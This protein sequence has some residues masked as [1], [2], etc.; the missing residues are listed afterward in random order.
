[1]I[2]TTVSFLNIAEDVSIKVFKKPIRSLKHDQ[3]TNSSCRNLL[4]HET[5]RVVE[6]EL[7]V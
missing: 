7:T 6:I 4:H 5:R 2:D 3:T 1:M